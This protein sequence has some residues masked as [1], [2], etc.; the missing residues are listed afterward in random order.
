MHI[1]IGR[2]ATVKDYEKKGTNLIRLS[3]IL[4]GIGIIVSA[5]LIIVSVR[6]THEN[7]LYAAVIN[8]VWPIILCKLMEAAGH[9]I[10]LMN[11][12]NENSK[13]M[14]ELL[15]KQGETEMLPQTAPKSAVEAVPMDNEP[16]N[17]NGEDENGIDA[18]IEELQK[19]FRN[20]ST[21]DTSY[22]IVKDCADENRVVITKEVER[23]ASK[24]NYIG[25]NY[26]DS[27]QKYKKIQ[28]NLAHSVSSQMES[29]GLNDWAVLFQVVDSAIGQQMLSIYKD[30]IVY[31]FLNE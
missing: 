18:F 26:M 3:K 14:I 29:C 16:E 10:I 11:E 21:E 12:Q 28:Q 31:D 4:V 23:L 25:E 30:E 20:E 6:D 2:P 17:R 9:G 7:L 13:K 19:T 1:G 22:S 15:E 24:I 27:W 8:I 5:V